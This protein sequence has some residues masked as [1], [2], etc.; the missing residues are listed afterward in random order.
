MSP[1]MTR[2]VGQ[3]SRGRWSAF[4]GMEER[5]GDKKTPAARR[6]ACDYKK[7]Q[8]ILAS[9]LDAET[10]DTCGNSAIYVSIETAFNGA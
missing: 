7:E 8:K 10:I 3:G 1:G 9:L 5:K 6:L 4:K 2:Y